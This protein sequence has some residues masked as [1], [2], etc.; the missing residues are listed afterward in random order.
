MKQLRFSKVL[1]LCF[2]IFFLLLIL[3][4]K[5]IGLTPSATGNISIK[6]IEAGVTAYAYRLTTV[7]WNTSINQ[8]LDPPYAWVDEV[9]SWIDTNFPNYSDPE[10]FYEDFYNEDTQTT[11]EATEFY[12][13]LISGVKGGSIDLDASYTK[14]LTGNNYYPVEDS[15]LT[16]S[17]TFE[18]C[19]M[20]TYLILIENGYM[21]YSPSVVNL[22]PKYIEGDGWV[23]SDGSVQVKST[24][25]QISK[26][27][28]GIKK[29]NFSTIDTLN[30]EILAD[31]PKYI[32]SALSKTYKVTDVLS[33]GLS[34][35]NSS[36]EVYG[37]N[38]NSETKLT[39]DNEY[40]IEKSSN[41]DFTISFIYENICQYDSVKITYTSKLLQSSSLIL[42]DG[43]K[44]TASLIYS[45]NP[46]DED[47]T[48][49]QEDTVTVYTYG[50]NITKVDKTDNSKV[51]AG[52]QFNL[53]DDNNHLYFVG[54]NGV[55]YLSDHASAGAT[56]VLEVN[57]NGLLCLYGLDEGTYY[58]NEF[59]A[60]DGY[61]ASQ[62]VYSLVIKDE[63]L[64]G[65][66]DDDS[67]G[68][69]KNDTNGIIEITFPNGKGFQLPI[70]GGMGTLVFIIGGIIFICAGIIILILIK[71]KNSKNSDI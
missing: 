20:G 54:N 22:T 44:N 23:L 43:N 45:N 48:Q 7:N 33:D 28:N 4:T 35:D 61:N 12:S 47:S 34:L 46:Y 2:A 24:R 15:S 40:K 62:N 1:I 32:D 67:E 63:N 14:T 8:P 9:Q 21:V 10:D 70:T 37:I 42:G 71:R 68:Y 41:N 36:I 11:S 26:T 18:N 50:L 29:D 60:P 59:K 56:D 52:A 17:V 53:S 3:D 58:L 13:K 5:S 66:I 30:F 39:L 49:V 57:S 16:G 55:Y 51:L 6:N 27:L 65:K 69:I 31:I 38:E 64:D 25:P 19:N